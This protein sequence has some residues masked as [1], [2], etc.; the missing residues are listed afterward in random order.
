MGDLMK[1]DNEIP[2]RA[3]SPKLNVPVLE[4]IKLSTCVVKSIH[5]TT[6]N[7]Y[8]DPYD[9]FEPQENADDTPGS[10]PELTDGSL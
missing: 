3:N 9:P 7:P 10:I 8:D 1:F 6:Y 5:P 2:K 4:P